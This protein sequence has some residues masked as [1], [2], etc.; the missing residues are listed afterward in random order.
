MLTSSKKIALCG[1]DVA[2]GPCVA[3]SCFKVI[4]LSQNYYLEFFI[5]CD[6]YLYI[7]FSCLY[8]HNPLGF[9]PDGQE[10]VADNHVEGRE[11]VPVH[12]QRISKL[13]C[14]NRAGNFTKGLAV[15]EANRFCVCYSKNKIN[16]CI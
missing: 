1:P 16:Y 3:P 7:S 4:I 12:V 9:V 10:G 14:K 11:G 8:N 6:L 5:E 15:L 2:R 13:C